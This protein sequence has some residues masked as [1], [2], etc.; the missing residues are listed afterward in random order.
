MAAPASAL[1]DLLSQALAGA[2]AALEDYLTGQSNLPGPRMN[3]AL[4]AQFAQLVGELVGQADLPVA[5]LEALLDSWAALSLAEAGVNQPREILPAT[6]VL[7]YGRVAVSRPDWW[8]DE[9]AKLRQ[10]ARD[11]RWRVREMVAT[12]LQTMLKSDWPRTLSVLQDWLASASDPLEVRA[13]VAAIAEPPILTSVAR[14]EAALQLQQKALDFILHI[15]NR[16][17][18]QIKQT[19]S[20]AFKV[21][22]QALGYTLSVAVAA[23]PEAGLAFMKEL[24]QS[25]DPDVQWIAR[26]NW[27]KQ[28][29]KKYL[30]AHD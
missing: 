23:A 16:Q 27:K 7:T 26:E 21:L 1:S 2:P 5:S 29:L 22:R 4:A 12:A 15:P 6:A 11:P 20:E 19:K 8:A 14:G 10:A 18:E 17:T 3:T 30:P 25:S 13:V 9:T 24:G 28:R